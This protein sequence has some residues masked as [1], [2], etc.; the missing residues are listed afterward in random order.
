MKTD[1]NDKKI[2]IF[3]ILKLIGAKALGLYNIFKLKPK[4]SKEIFKNFTE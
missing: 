4:T 1:A 2:K 3:K